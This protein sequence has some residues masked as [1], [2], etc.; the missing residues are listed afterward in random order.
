VYRTAHD[1]PT[2]KLLGAIANN[3]GTS[4][5]VDVAADGSLGAV[6]PLSDTS[7]LTFAANL[8]PATFDTSFVAIN[9]LTT[10]T[11]TSAAPVVASAS[12]N[13]VAADVGAYL[14]VKSGLNWIPGFYLITAVAAN[15]ATVAG[16]VATL[17]TPGGPGTWSVDY[18]RLL[19]PR[20][21]YT[22]LVLSNA[23]GTTFSSAAFPAGFNQVGNSLQVMGGTGFYQLVH[24]ITANATIDKSGGVG[25]STGGIAFLGGLGAA[26]T[27]VVG[28]NLVP[29]ASPVGFSAGGGWAR[30][31][32]QVFRYTGLSGNTLTGVPASGP[33]SITV[34]ISFG[35]AVEPA[36]CLLG[37]PAGGV[38]SILYPIRAGDPV[39][40]R[41]V[42]NDLAAQAV[43][44]AVTFQPAR[45]SYA[46]Q[47]LADGAIGYWRLDELSGNFIDKVSGLVG[48]PSGGIT[49]GQVGALA[50]GNAAALFNGSTGKVALPN[51]ALTA[52]WTAEAWVNTTV[53]KQQSFF[54]NYTGSAGTYC[55]L[56]VNGKAFL[57][58][59]TAAPTLLAAAGANL[60]DG[61]WHHIAIT[62]DGATTTMYVDGALIRTGAM[63]HAV[64]AATPAA[65]G[66]GGGVADYFAGTL[67]DVALYP[68]ALTPAQIAQ[69][70]AL[71]TASLIPAVVDDGVI[72]GDLIQD[73]RISETEARARGLAKLAERSAIAVSV[74]YQTHDQN[75]HAGRTIG[76]TSMLGVTGS[77]R[78][79]AVTI[80]DFHPARLPRHTVEASSARF[81]LEDLLRVARKGL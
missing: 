30:T 71:R 10:T 73:G 35:A 53:A 70:S 27:L 21:A 51:R 19:T 13:F 81:T 38:G 56:D 37:I 61:A 42:V 17:A 8:A 29:L 16:A 26:A 14:Y 28:S 65:I 80:S 68:V 18:S 47:V 44:A 24:R 5:G 58:M 60:A 36:P 22:D 7:G 20:V 2:L 69:H 6:A 43:I 63:T 57:Y 46:S 54:S 45:S 4:F 40:L 52:A 39:N 41:V 74:R 49:R 67:D 32:Q 25:F 64:E 59:P 15:A 66:F 78:I 23:P 76:V 34:A 3:T 33:G 12:Y 48:T 11:G 79:Q 75:T 1:D 31:G 50:D 62:N 77:Y 72:T 9:T 55:G